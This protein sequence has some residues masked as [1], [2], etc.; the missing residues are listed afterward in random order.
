[1]SWS[2]II[3]LSDI[4]DFGTYKPFLK[5]EEDVNFDNKFCILKTNE[6]NIAFSFYDLGVA[7]SVVIDNQMVFLSFGN[8]YY[9]INLFKKKILTKCINTLSTIFEIIKCNSRGCV[10]FVGEVSL[11]CFNLAG[12]LMWRNTYENS[13][14]DWVISDEEIFIVFENDQKMS[15]S[16]EDGNGVVVT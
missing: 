4:N 14:Y 1:M 11:I 15:V 12:Q 7:P 16:F 9:V 10:V 3:I 2:E 5:L 6:G 13:I 8:S